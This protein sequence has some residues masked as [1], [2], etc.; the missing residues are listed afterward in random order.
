MAF[1]KTSFGKTSRGITAMGWDT[2]WQLAL[3]QFGA[4]PVEIRIAILVA[5]AFVALLILIGF[6]YAFRSAE[7][8]SAP[9]PLEMPRRVVIAPVPAAVVQAAPVAQESGKTQPFRV[10]K[11]SPRATRKSAKHTISRQRA[12]RPLIRREAPNSAEIAAPYS[13]LPPRR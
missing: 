3:K 13:P 8:K 11:P 6:K 10:L 1:R 5:A 7:P 2:V 9:P 4:E 12:T